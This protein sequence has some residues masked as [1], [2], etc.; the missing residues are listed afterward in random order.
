MAILNGGIKRSNIQKRDTKE[1][2]IELSI[3]IDGSGETKID[4]GIGFF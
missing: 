3:N 4:S 2:K 1:T